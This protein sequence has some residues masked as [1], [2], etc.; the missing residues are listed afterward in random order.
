MA[1]AKA[2]RAVYEA[3]GGRKFFL[4][5]AFLVL[6]PFYASLPAMLIQRL[7]HG[8]GLQEFLVPL[9]T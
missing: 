5:L 6:L 1:E 8:P 3:G 7:I 9:R 4:A 2:E